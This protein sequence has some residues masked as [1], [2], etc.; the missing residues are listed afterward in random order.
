MIYIIP[1]TYGVQVKQ[2]EEDQDNYTDV[3]SY[4]N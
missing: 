3:D 1:Q 2:F 4:D